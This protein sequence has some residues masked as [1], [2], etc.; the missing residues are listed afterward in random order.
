M[1][2][3]LLLADERL[4]VIDTAS[5]FGTRVTG[6][7]DARVLELVGT[8]DVELGPDTKVAWSWLS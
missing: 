6:G 5:T 3:L 4:L 2:A 1:H 8:T 7:Q